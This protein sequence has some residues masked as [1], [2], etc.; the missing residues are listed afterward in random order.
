MKLADRR[1]TKYVTEVKKVI[2]L[3][4]HATNAEILAYVRDDHPT[5]SATTIHRITQRL[6]EDGELGRCPKALDGS[7]RY[8]ANTSQHDHFLCSMC[9]ALRD[10][11]LPAACLA[12]IRC[13]LEDCSISGPLT[14]SG[15]CKGCSDAW[16]KDFPPV[17][18][19]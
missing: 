11:T 2:N 16:H 13:N 15:A 8:D 12:I 1:V 17:V 18:N 14:V 6:Y 9:G 7:V 19:I 10:I 3:R 5:L 4:G